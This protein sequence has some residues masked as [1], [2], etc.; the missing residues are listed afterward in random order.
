M[1]GHVSPEDSR[2]ECPTCGETEI[3]TNLMVGEKFASA[4][5]RSRGFGGM[6][7]RKV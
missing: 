6:P 4:K 7:P 1:I 3:G 5:G 2:A